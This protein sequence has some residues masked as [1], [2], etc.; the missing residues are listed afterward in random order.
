MS[1]IRVPLIISGR[2]YYH[3]LLRNFEKILKEHNLLRFFIGE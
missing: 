2:N 1:N 3:E